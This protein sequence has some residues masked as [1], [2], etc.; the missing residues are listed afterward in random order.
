MFEHSKTVIITKLLA[1]R[2]K[3]NVNPVVTKPSKAS[4]IHLVKSTIK[5]KYDMDQLLWFFLV[6]MLVE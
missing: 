3:V 6:K 1:F 2:L 4:N 5:H